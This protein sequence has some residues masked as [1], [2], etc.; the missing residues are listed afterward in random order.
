M[1]DLTYHV[2]DVF[3]DV[4]FA[5]NPLA[6]V[7]GADGLDTAQLQA[8]A[9]EFN[10]SESAFP[11]A[12]RAATYRLRIFTP[13]TEL[14]FA[15]H[16]S[17]GAAAVLRSLGRIG[18]GPAVM[19][20]GAGLL[21]VMVSADRVE[22]TAATPSAGPALSVAPWLA[23]VGL[24]EGDAGAAPPRVCS[25]G[26]RQA[27]VE[28]RSSEAVRWA[29]PD[30]A[31]IDDLGDVETLSVFAWDAATRTAHTR[32]FAPNV[33]VPEDP[34]TG[35]AAAA[36]G[37]WLAASGYVPGDGE[38]AYVVTQGAEIGRPSRIDGTVVTRDGNAVEC[39]IAG[40]TVPVATGTIRVP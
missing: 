25:A 36:F 10:L 20:C 1:A 34:A 14:P 38:T 29:E 13:G 23:A 39:R 37:A 21:P 5:G 17:V 40:T 28:V 27:F 15:G 18:H 31:A 26:L 2:V 16:P 22:V 9:R 33:G 6:V 11:M 30:S 24:S 32:V 3:T 12:S 8:L 35:S 19:E 7:L 4:P